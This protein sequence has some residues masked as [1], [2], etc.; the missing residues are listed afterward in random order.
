[1][2]SVELGWLALDRY[3][4]LRHAAEGKVLPELRLLRISSQVT[5][6]H[7][8]TVARFLLE[9]SNREIS[10]VMR[11]CGQSKFLP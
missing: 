2:V 6:L 7:G 10:K 3:N 9:G 8:T 4:F 5:I 11:A 1:M